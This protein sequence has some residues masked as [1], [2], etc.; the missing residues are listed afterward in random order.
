MKIE[1]KQKLTKLDKAFVDYI[2]AAL[3]EYSDVDVNMHKCIE[4]DLIDRGM[5]EGDAFNCAHELSSNYI[6]L[7]EGIILWQ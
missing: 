5:D 2:N 7:T 4:L 6:K 1:K 3:S